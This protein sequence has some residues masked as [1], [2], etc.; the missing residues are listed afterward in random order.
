MKKLLKILLCLILVFSLMPKEEAKAEEGVITNIVIDGDTISWDPY[1][2]TA[3]YWLH[4]VDVSHYFLTE[5]TTFDLRTLMAMSSVE[6]G[7]YRIEIQAEDA[8]HYVIAS[9]TSDAYYHHESLGKLDVPQNPV[10]RG[11]K[12][13]WDPVTNADRYRV[14]IYKNGEWMDAIWTYGTNE[15]DLR[16]YIQ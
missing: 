7:D 15:L 5:S 6:T 16:N 1:P 11:T 3:E 2:G 9:G 12:A 14:D 4:V 13:G 8:D 10:W